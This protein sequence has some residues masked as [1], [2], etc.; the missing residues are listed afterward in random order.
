MFRPLP[1]QKAEHRDRQEPEQGQN[2]RDC[3][4]N[5]HAHSSHGQTVEVGDVVV[6]DRFLYLQRRFKIEVFQMS[7]FE[8][9]GAV[10]ALSLIHI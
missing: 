10:E 7:V 3:P 6:I 1:D 5:L 2:I 9:D 8:A 4:L